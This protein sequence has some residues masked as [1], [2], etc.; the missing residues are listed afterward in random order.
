MHARDIH[1]TALNEG[2]S[3]SAVSANVAIERNAAASTSTSKSLVGTLASSLAAE[4]C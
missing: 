3:R 2:A 1:A 4:A